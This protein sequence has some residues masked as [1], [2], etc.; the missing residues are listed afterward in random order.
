MKSFI[1]ML[2]PMAIALLLG[3]CQS[4]PGSQPASSFE[5]ELAAGRLESAQLALSKEPST[6]E[7]LAERRQRL[8]DAYLQRSR[9]ALQQGDVNGASNALARARSLMPRAPGVAADV[10]G[11]QQTT[12]PAPTPPAKER[13]E[14]LE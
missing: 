6:P 1:R 9:E 13:C 10:S 3:A 12:Q 4:F 14:P 5:S 7:Q 8:A 2:S 11:L